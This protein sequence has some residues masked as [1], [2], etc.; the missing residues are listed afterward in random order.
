MNHINIRVIQKAGIFGPENDRNRGPT[1][2][3][4]DSKIRTSLELRTISVSNVIELS[5]QN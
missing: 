1:R 4:T 5:H 3:G 2:S